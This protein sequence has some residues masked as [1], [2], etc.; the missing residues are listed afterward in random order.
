M[1]A[2]RRP[3][4]GAVLLVM[5]ALTAMLCG[6]LL[7]VFNV[8]QQVSAKARL[9]GAADS[10]A[11]S[12]AVWEAR[13]L[14]LQAY[15][16]RAIVANEVAIG[17]FVSL[18]SWSRYMD[19][20]LTNSAL[21][22][23]WVPYLGEALEALSGVWRGVDRALQSTLPPM[24]V[25]V[26]VWNTD[27]LAR[28]EVLAQQQAALVAQQITHQVAQDNVAAAEQSAAAPLLAARNLAA[29]EALTRTYTAEGSQRQ[30]LRTLV[31]NSRD[32]FTARRNWSESLAG[33]VSL[34]KRG[35]TD[36]IRYDAWRGLDDL[37]LHTASWLGDAEAP[38]VWGG[39]EF[40]Q[41]V[42]NLR[43]SHGGSWSRNPRST[44]RANRSRVIRAGYRGLSA[45][46]DIAQPAQRTGLQAR[47]VVELQQ[48]A[49]S[50]GT[51]ET[52]LN[53]AG[54]VAP[55]HATHVWQPTYPQDRL[56]ALGAAHV[57][58]QRPV[59][60]RDG[61]SEY[62]SLFNPYWEARLAPVNA[63]DRQLAAF[64]KGLSVDPLEALP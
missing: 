17:Q 13:S 32:G 57:F 23:S 46:R 64:S 25:V 41:S 42:D 61:R 28:A 21:V 35:G 16:N 14:N 63:A 49:R 50:V 33:L 54:S 3:Q 40:R 36:L 47:W 43:G 5:L 45:Y 15:M 39:A 30:R 1:R 12:A 8:G 20:L 22:T 6:C 10:A 51:S 58:Y 53:G 60:R 31:M 27:M 48:S 18:Q 52:T 55:G 37:S 19:R 29:F 59:A 9:I 26:S 2:S 24:E 62:P 44:R 34:E 11:L 56:Y 4:R 38:L 7:L